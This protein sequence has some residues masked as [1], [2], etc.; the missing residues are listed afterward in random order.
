ME[1]SWVQSPPGSNEIVILNKTR[2]DGYSF[3]ALLGKGSR[4]ALMPNNNS[5]YFMLL[6]ESSHVSVL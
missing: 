6:N 2:N 3:L 1:K 4:L 5:L